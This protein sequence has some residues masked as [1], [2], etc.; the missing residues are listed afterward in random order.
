MWSLYNKLIEGIPAGVKVHSY[1]SARN[2]TEVVAETGTGVAL[3]VHQ[4]EM[5]RMCPGS[6]AEMELHEMANLVYSWNFVE[7]SLGLAAINAWYNNWEKVSTLPGFEKQDTEKRDLKSRTKQNAFFAFAEELEGK[8]VAVIGHFP[9]IEKQIAH[10]CELSILERFP[11]PG[12]YPDSACEYI[13]PEQDYVFITGMTLTNKTLPRLLQI[14]ERAKVSLVGP[15][16]PMAEVLW[17]FGVDNLSGFVCTDPDI[18][19]EV[20][21]RGS[22]REIFSGGRMVSVHKV[23]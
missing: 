10:L 6:L 7:A 2:W 13:L 12:D 15:S 17:D 3:T 14:C 5:S 21:R 18:A 22:E 9:Y 23:Q 4:S 11:G 19:D 1:V 20:I 8:K 16:V